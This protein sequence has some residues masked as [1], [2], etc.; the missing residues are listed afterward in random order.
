MLSES[1]IPRLDEKGYSANP[2][3]HTINDTVDKVNLGLVQKVTQLAL[4]TL[5]CLASMPSEIDETMPRVM[6]D[7]QPQVKQSSVEISGQFET[8]FPIY[9]VVYPG[10]VTAQVDRAKNTYT[11][12]IPL[13][14]GANQVRVAAV[15]ALGARSVEQT[16]FFEPDFEWHS[17]NV[18]PNPSRK[19]DELI[20][21]RTEA[22]LPIEEMGIYIYSSDGML[23]KQVPGVADRG[24]SRIWRTWWNLKTSYGL[25]VAAGVYVC[26]FEILVKGN[27]YTRHRKLAI[28]Q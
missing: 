19:A 14:P 4:V 16:I 1:D 24:D 17:V 27:T 9:I 22:N 8:P 15:H 28:L 26:R 13:K 25:Q 3:Y 2:Y 5:N 10:N 6:V 21:F 20:V 23:V 18:F 7:P 12:T 11:A